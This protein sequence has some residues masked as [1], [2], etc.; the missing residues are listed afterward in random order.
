MIRW[1]GMVAAVAVLGAGPLLAAEEGH[2]SGGLP[3]LDFSTYPSQL[4]WLV[5]SFALLLYLMKNRALPRVTEILE[6]RQA[7]IQGD[8]DQ[9]AALRGEAEAAAA[10][11]E[12]AVAQARSAASQRVRETQE[13]AA[14]EL[15]RRQ[16]AVDAEIDVFVKAA[17]DRIGAA[18]NKAFGEIGAVAA[19]V[20]QSAVKRLAGIEIGLDEAKAVVA[21]AEAR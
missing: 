20:A 3:Q 8:L 18:K 14:A 19:E 1:M 5:I 12:Q 7:R 10:Q 15:A 21:G 17:D 6:T 16:A 9:A 4:F 11:Y 13:Q 2:S